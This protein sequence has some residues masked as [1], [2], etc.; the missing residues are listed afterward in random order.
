MGSAFGLCVTHLYCFWTY[1]PMHLGVRE[2]FL[3]PFLLLF[4][5]YIDI[6]APAPPHV[7]NKEIPIYTV[8]STIVT[9][10]WLLHVIAMVWCHIHCSALHHIPAIRTPSG[11]L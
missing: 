1:A 6:M 8:Y 3:L 11:W 2:P 7:L 4:L 10:L 9:H 5:W